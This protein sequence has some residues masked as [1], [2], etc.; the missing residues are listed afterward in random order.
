MR[1]AVFEAPFGLTLIERPSPI[2]LAGEALV[3]VEAAGLCAGDLYIYLGKNPYVTYPRIGGHEI[4]GRLE[5][6]GL[7]TV[8]PAIG[9]RVVVEPFIGCGHCYPCRV[10][11]ANCCVNL[12]IVGVHRE[13]GFAEQVCVP[14]DRLHGVPDGL[15]P[16]QASFAEPVAIGVQAARRGQVT[17]ADTVLILGAGPIGLATLEVIRAG[18]ARVY[19]ADLARDRLDVA[20]RLGAIPLEAGPGLLAAVMLMT[21]GEGM[22]VV[23]EAT[24]SPQAMAQTADLVAA[25]GRIVIVGLVKPGIEI[26][27]PGLDLTRKE[28]TIVGSRASTG[29]FPEA[30]A[31]LA[32]GAIRYPTVATAFD[33][34]A[35]PELFADLANNA[36]G[37]QKAVFIREPG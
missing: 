16:I 26:P 22:P 19:V 31:L 8:G 13:G 25:G 4:A 12:S 21:H 10:G 32:S 3:R 37:I 15:T 36:A 1:A 24:G 23:I 29:C 34:G 20:A 35:A 2:P 14:V 6:L 9:S 33:L 27:W 5:A 30:L 7:D 18:G 11:K 17:A 28:M